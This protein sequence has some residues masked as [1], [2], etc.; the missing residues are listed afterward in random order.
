MKAY[1]INSVEE[2][3]TEV[4]QDW[5]LEQLQAAVEGHIAM[6]GTVEI[7]DAPSDVVYCDDEGLIKNSMRPFTL[8]DGLAHPYVGQLVWI[9]ST[10]DGDSADA[11]TSLEDVR[12]KVSFHSFEE[13]Y[14]R[15]NQ[16]E[17]H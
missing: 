10:E 8:I 17:F 6:A 9:G 4:D 1:V 7:E 11:R 2:T 13:I 15:T 12:A 16:G 14:E 3:V 5:T